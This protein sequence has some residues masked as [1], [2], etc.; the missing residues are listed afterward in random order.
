M[1]TKVETGRHSLGM[2][3]EQVRFLEFALPDEVFNSV[4][5]SDIGQEY[6]RLLHTIGCNP[7]EYSKAERLYR[8]LLSSILADGN[9][10]STYIN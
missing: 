9:F 2:E 5:R 3:L 6:H 8:T 1:K 10:W 7:N 4:Y